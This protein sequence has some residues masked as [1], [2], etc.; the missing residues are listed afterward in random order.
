MARSKSG[1]TLAALNAQIAALQAQADMAL[2]DLVEWFAV[3][4]EAGDDTYFD[5]Y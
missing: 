2:G 3:W 1:P 5:I 4:V